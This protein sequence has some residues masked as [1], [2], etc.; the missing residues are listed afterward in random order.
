MYILRIQIVLTDSR[1]RTA[2]QHHMLQRN[3]MTPVYAHRFEGPK[4]D[5]RVARTDHESR[6]THA[7]LL[8]ARPDEENRSDSTRT[9][10]ATFLPPSSTGNFPPRHGVGR[11]WLVTVTAQP[12]SRPKHTH[13]GQTDRGR[14]TENITVSA[15]DRDD[16]RLRPQRTARI[17]YEGG[18]DFRPGSGPFDNS[19]NST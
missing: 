5:S 1:I 8:N 6:F 19:R 2:A 4:S 11:R 9:A 3:T 17:A 14:A 10:A 16:Q 7:N 13:A 18:A 12:V 15:R